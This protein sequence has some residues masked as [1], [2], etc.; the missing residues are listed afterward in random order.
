MGWFFLQMQYFLYF[1]FL[2]R[3]PRKPESK[4]AVL[5]LIFKL[6][7]AKWQSWSVLQLHSKSSL[8]FRT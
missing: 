3:I 5:A 6:M 4:Q 1:C 8:E 2:N 7:N